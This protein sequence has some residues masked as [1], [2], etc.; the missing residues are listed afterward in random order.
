MKK[1]IIPT[2]SEK[3]IQQRSEFKKLKLRLLTRLINTQETK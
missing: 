3:F 2:L 1:S